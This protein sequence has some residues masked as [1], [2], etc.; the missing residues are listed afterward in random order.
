MHSIY[1]TVTH[2]RKVKINRYVTQLI[3][4]KYLII[5][6]REENLILQKVI[7][8]LP[9]FIKIPRFIVSFIQTLNI[10][11]TFSKC[12][13][14]KIL[15]PALCKEFYEKL[16][17]I[18]RNCFFIIHEKTMTLLVFC[19]KYCHKAKCHLLS[20]VIFLMIYMI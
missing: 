6:R 12:Y 10:S 3:I 16:R 14:K 11:V 20:Y 2:L 13:L 1:L 19:G 7:I 8:F 15:R 4:I 5:F 18:Q 9:R 17:N